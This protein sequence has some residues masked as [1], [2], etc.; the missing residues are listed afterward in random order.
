[1]AN[2]YRDS[3]NHFSMYSLL[4]SLLDIDEKVEIW[5]Y[6]HVAMVK[7]MIGTKTGTGGSTGASG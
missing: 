5:R 3:S 1:M 6:R 2:I 7:R 4:E